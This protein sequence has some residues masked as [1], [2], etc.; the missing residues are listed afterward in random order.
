MKT[1]KIILMSWC[2]WCLG[3]SHAAPL[4]TISAPSP[5]LF[6]SINE[7]SVNDVIQSSFR[8]GSARNLAERFDA[9]LELFIDTEAV[10]FPEVRA[11]HAEL[12]LSTFFKKHPPQ[13]FQFVYQG[14]SAS[15]RYV[16]GL[17]QTGG[18]RFSVYM[19]IRS[20]AHQRLV[21]NTLH[22][23]KG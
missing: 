12:I 20:D 14:G 8:A 23:R 5:V 18:Q 19:L 17:Y 21:I 6:A 1:C 2:C 15:L 9:Q 10:D 22:L 3:T 13:S 16:T 11:K 4:E 7:N